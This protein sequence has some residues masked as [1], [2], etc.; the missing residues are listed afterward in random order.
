MIGI[1][2]GT[3]KLKDETKIATCVVNDI[4]GKDDHIWDFE[5]EGFSNHGGHILPRLGRTL[6]CG[7]MD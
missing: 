7:Y 2:T 1:N 5:F 4:D 6:Y 3:A